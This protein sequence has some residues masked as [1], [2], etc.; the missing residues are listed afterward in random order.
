MLTCSSVLD[1]SAASLQASLL[2]LISL[3]PTLASSA[4]STPALIPS[5]STLLALQHSTTSTTPS[6][7]YQ[8]TLDPSRG[9]AL[10]DNATLKV[11]PRVPPPQQTPRPVLPHHPSSGGLSAGPRQFIPSKKVAAPAALGPN[12]TTDEVMAWAAQAAAGL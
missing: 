3:R 12:A 5:H 4:H 11:H 8:G 6:P 10:K 9:F 2:Q 7:A 1:L